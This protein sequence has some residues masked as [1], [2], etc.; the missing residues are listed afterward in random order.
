MAR[1]FVLAHNKYLCGVFTQQKK[2]WQAILDK[3]GITQEEM[4]KHYDLTGTY[5]DDWHDKDYGIHKI[6]NSI[7]AYSQL[8]NALRKTDDL[9]LE[10]EVMHERFAIHIRHTNELE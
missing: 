9:L 5:F 8:N 10:E 1:V 2:L 4:N 6:R 7:K 3:L